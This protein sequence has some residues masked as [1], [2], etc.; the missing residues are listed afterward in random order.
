MDMRSRLMIAVCL[1][2]LVGVGPGAVR[3]EVPAAPA[4]P[5]TRA[6]SATAAEKQPSEKPDEFVVVDAMPKVLVKVEPKYPEAARKR[7]EQGTVHVRVRVGKDGSVSDVKVPE[8]KGAT[9]DLDRA[10]VEALRQ[11]KFQPATAKGK[12]VATYVVVPVKFRLTE[13]KKKK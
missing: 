4:D 12:P 9:P 1:A 11:W 6:P 13:D 8:G 7:G 5:A 10:A 3:A 2:A